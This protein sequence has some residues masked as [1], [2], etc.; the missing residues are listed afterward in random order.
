MASNREERLQMR[1]RGAGTRKIKEVDFG[2]SLGFGPSVEEPSQAASLLPAN[3][4]LEPTPVPQSLLLHDPS[5]LESAATEPFQTQSA[6]SPI[7][8]NPPSQSQSVP[9][10]PGSARNKLPP[11][12]STFDI[13]TEDDPELERTS[14]RRKIEPPTVVSP[15][16]GAQTETPNID[17]SENGT[18]VDSVPPP[19]DEGVAIPIR[20]IASSQAEALDQAPPAEVPSIPTNEANGKPPEAPDEAPGHLETENSEHPAPEPTRV[21]GTASPPSDTS[22]GRGRGRGKSRRPSPSQNDISNMEPVEPLELAEAPSIEPPQPPEPVE[23]P[24]ERN[25]REPEPPKAGGKRTRG[26]TPASVQA[27]EAPAT[28]DEAPIEDASSEPLPSGATSKVLRGRKKKILEPTEETTLASQGSES[29]ALQ[30]ER[31]VEPNDVSSRVAP[32]SSQVQP[33]GLDKGKKRAGRPKKQASQSPESSKEY[34]AGSRKRQREER[35]RQAQE[36]PEQD[37][38]N[39]DASRAGKRRRQRKEREPTPRQDDQPEPEPEVEQFGAEKRKK[40]REER[41]P[42]PQ[43]EQPEPDAELPTSRA[44]KK[45]QP[46]LQEPTPDRE[47]QPEPE[48]EP[49]AAPE[50]QPECEQSKGTKRRRGGRPTAQ[51]D[52]PTQDETTEEQ[53]QPT[54]RKTRQPRGETVPVTVHRLANTASLGGELQESAS[55]DDADEIADNQPAKLPTRGGVNP[56]DVLAQICRETLEKTLTTLKNGI[57][58]EANTARRAEWTLRRKAVEAFGTELEGR[59]FDLSE[60]LDSNFMLSAKVKKAKRNM[61]DRRNRLDQVRRE[62]EAIALRMDAVRRE[63]AKEE[64]AGV[65]RSTI[66]HSLHNL[67]LALERGQSRTSTE[68]EPLTAGLEFRLRSM[69]QKVSSTVAGAQG[70]LLNQIKAFNAQLAKAAQQLEG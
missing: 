19:G 64:H 37:Q 69:A 62:R 23:V 50:P 53:P 11:R 30:S 12:P 17:A 34:H 24:Q 45:K 55:E 33:N 57:A 70:G 44:G 8:V 49:E 31:E 1:Q 58:N 18:I 61:M 67:D 56:A 9:R 40:R 5:S 6:L 20:T 15:T 41:E 27:S 13:P 3:S 10:T 65:A 66:N 51:P 47:E 36:N 26:R 4:R 38:P 35:E 7:Q 28:V 14:K 43:N 22:K 42:I 29:S 16:M 21:N 32:H 25:S 59:L 46:V 60:M 2:F 39:S 48:P 68:D 52:Q 63:H 54:K